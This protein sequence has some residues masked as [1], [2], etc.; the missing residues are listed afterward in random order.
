MGRGT[1]LHDIIGRVI[2]GIGVPLGPSGQ[3]VRTEVRSKA[4]GACVLCA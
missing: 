1:Y 4:V 3:T 2:V